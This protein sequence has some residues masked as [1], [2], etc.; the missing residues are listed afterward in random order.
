[1]RDAKKKS[2]SDWARSSLTGHVVFIQIF[3]S[4]PLFIVFLGLSYYDGILTLG[5]A[6]QVLIGASIAGLILA[7]LSWY[8]IMLRV[9]KKYGKKP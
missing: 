1:M 4:V 6:L 5:R 8:T 7:I 9:M 2:L 3:C